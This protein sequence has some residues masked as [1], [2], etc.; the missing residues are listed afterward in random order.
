MDS[1]P[2]IR[3]ETER[4]QSLHEEL[5]TRS[6]KIEHIIDME[7]CIRITLCSGETCDFKE[8]LSCIHRETLEDRKEGFAQ[9]IITLLSQSHLS[10]STSV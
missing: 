1:F 10:L 4:I 7:P 8:A 6:A 9:R 3:E 2:F 5:M